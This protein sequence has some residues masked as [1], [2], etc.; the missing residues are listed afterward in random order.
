[1]NQ[2]KNGNHQDVAVIIESNEK[3]IKFYSTSHIGDIYSSYSEDSENQAIIDK[4]LSYISELTSNYCIHSTPENKIIIDNSDPHQL[5]RD[6]IESEKMFNNFS[7]DYLANVL[8]EAGLGETRKTYI[9]LLKRLPL[10]QALIDALNDPRSSNYLDSMFP[11]LKENPTME[12]F[13]ESFVNTIR[14]MNDGLGYKNLR[15]SFRSSLNIN[16]DKAYNWKDPFKELEKV[17]K[18]FLPDGLE[19]LS[20]H[21]QSK[22][23]WFDKLVEAYINIDMAGF[24]EDKVKIDNKGKKN[25]FK[26]TTEDAFHSAF[27]SMCDVYV[28]N[29]KKAY[30]KTKEVYKHLQIITKVFSP[31][32]FKEY[33]DHYLNYLNGWPTLHLIMEHIKKMTPVI[34]TH[35]DGTG[36]LRTYHSNY[37][38]FDFF[39]KIYISQSTEDSEPIIFLSKNKP[40]NGRFTLFAE[41]ESVVKKLLGIFGED[42]EGVGPLTLEE[43]NREQILCERN[44]QLNDIGLRLVQ[45]NGYFQ[46]YLETHTHQ[47]K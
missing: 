45:Y 41:V 8:E 5:F 33:Y 25:T 34:S 43:F 20:E 4:D 36:I 39:N 40:T 47:A 1:M 46:L 31:K 35:Q 29:D 13:F 38:F 32:E 11:G 2:I 30:L 12:G 6:R 18:P 15:N 44:W 37:Y 19:Q 42:V 27:A 7:L 24:K 22:G 23:T 9:D 17:L 21:S 16:R 10:E 3:F 26:N 28:V 14:G